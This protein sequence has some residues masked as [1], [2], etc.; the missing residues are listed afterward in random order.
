MRIIAGRYR[1]R[2][3]PS[4]KNTLVRP[5]EDRIKESLFN[6]IQSKT[7]GQRVLDL[8]AGSGA[9]GLE[10]ISRGATFVHFNDGSKENTR[11]I[12]RLLREI[13]VE[14]KYVVTQRDYESLLKDHSCGPYDI[15]FI[16][17]PYHTDLALK[18]LYLIDE[19]DLLAKDGIVIV[20]TD[21]PIEDAPL[22][23]IDERKYR[24]TFLTFYRKGD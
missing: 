3:I 11:S 23:Q 22:E 15:I 18:S 16:D 24:N 21:G 20:E 14:E 6:I 2:K 9:I 4:P 1:G 8:F 13:N 12:V 10:F 7:V 17:P 5:T 19:G